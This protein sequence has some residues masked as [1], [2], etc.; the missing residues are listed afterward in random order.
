MPGVAG[1]LQA[2]GT[3]NP[4]DQLIFLGMLDFQ[5]KVL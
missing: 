4:L 2:K 5:N 1:Y 3:S